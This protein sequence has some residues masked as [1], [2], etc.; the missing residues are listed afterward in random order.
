MGRPFVV[1]RR[2][3]G[4]DVGEQPPSLDLV[5]NRRGV[6][7]SAAHADQNREAELFRSKIACGRVDELHNLRC[8]VR[9]VL[10]E[11]SVPLLMNQRL[12]LVEIVG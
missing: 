12:V 2:V 8:R 11:S 6:A 5:G 10:R 7:A 4:R 1:E 9:T 3:N